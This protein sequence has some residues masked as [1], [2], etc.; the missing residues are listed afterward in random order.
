MNRTPIVVLAAL[1]LALSL[2]LELLHARAYLE[3]TASAFCATGE[4]LDCTSVALSRYSV[5]LGVPLPLWGALGFIAIAVAAVRG[6]RWLLPLTG[7]AALA[8][9][10]LF[11]LELAAIGALCLLCEGVHLVCFALVALA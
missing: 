10:V 7:V 11:V 5:L 1:G 8:S 4:R 9:L 3:P 6:S 2:A